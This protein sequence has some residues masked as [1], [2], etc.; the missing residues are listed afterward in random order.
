MS[1]FYE[2]KMLFRALESLFGQQ[3]VFDLTFLILLKTTSKWWS[4]ALQPYGE[5]SNT[6]ALK[7]TEISTFLVYVRKM[8]FRA[9]ERERQAQR[10]RERERDRHRGYR[11]SDCAG[12]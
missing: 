5:L 9:R 3:C 7:L 11:G 4:M 10:E 2:R 6:F 1:F 8:L 12:R